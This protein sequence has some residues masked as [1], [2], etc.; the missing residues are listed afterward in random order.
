MTSLSPAAQ[1]VKDAPTVAAVLRA[2]A[3]QVAKNDP[4]G[5]TAEDCIRGAER[6]HMRGKFYTIAAELEA[7]Q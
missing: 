2:A 4:L 1:A 3:D 7:Q 6:E 5:D